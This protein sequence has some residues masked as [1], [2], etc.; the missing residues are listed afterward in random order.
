VITA[1]TPTVPGRERLLEQCR[2]SVAAAGLKHLVR[3]DIERRGPA[4]VRNDLAA[5][6]DTPWLLCLDDD[7]LLLSHFLSVVE[8]E[9]E[10]ADVVYTAWYLTGAAEPQPLDRFDA[11]YLRVQ[12]FIPVTACVR[13]HLFRAVGGFR[14]VPLEDHDLWLRLL[15]AGARFTYVPVVCWR[16]RRQPGSRT[17]TEGDR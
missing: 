6:V 5:Q 8:P 14:D 16:Y 12:N 4:V 9:L 17:E 3:L 7:D 1:L 11:D 15:D 2:A 10:H 13:T